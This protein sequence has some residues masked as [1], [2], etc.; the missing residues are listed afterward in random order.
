MSFRKYGG[1]TFSAKHN[2]VHS[3][4]NNTKNLYV[5]NGVGQTN[6]YIDFYS[7]ISCNILNTNQINSSTIAGGTSTFDYLNVG[8]GSF[9]YLTGATGSFEYLS[10]PNF[11]FSSAIF[12]SIIY[13][14]GGITG[15]TGSF[16]YVNGGTGSFDYLTGA[17]GYFEYLSC[18][19][20]DFSSAIFNSTIYAEGG[21]T[22]ATGSFQYLE[23]ANTITGPSLNVGSGQVTCGGITG[24]TGSFQYLESAN[25]ITGP[26]LNVGS[27]QVTCGGIT[28][29]TGSFQYLVSAN[30]TKLSGTTITGVATLS[31]TTTTISSPTTNL[32]GTTTTLSG[33]TTNLNSTTTN[34]NSAT[35][36]FTN[37]TGNTAA[38]VTATSFNSTSDYRIK[39]NVKLLDDTFTVDNLN[40][41]TYTLKGTTQPGLGVIAHELQEEYPF[42]VTGEKDG[43]KTQSVN[44]IYLIG[45]LI[46]EIKDLK[47]IVSIMKTQISDLQGSL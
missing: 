25:T 3:N 33:T 41:V 12:T 38:T 37:L 19:N 10:C 35:T 17:T 44:Y 26:S 4:I 45:I 18:P 31:G 6:S 14:E 39:E 5:T 22:G 46:K 29:T 36:K 21:I 24:A 34:L 15:P 23:S 9:D 20:F 30:T 27:G 47:K 43:D 28:G 1:T 13:A 16:D 8:T 32:S 11:D 40:P 7:D 42:M 2:N